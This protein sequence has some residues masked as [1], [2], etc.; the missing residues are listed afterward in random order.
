MKDHDE[1]PVIEARALAD[2]FDLN[3]FTAH[4]HETVKIKLGTLR[5]AA[6]LFRILCDD[7]VEQAEQ[8]RA[9][10]DCV[11]AADRI[12]QRLEGRKTPCQP[13]PATSATESPRS[14]SS[15]RSSDLPPAARRP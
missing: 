1:E 7:A 14:A 9:A 10:H 4:D 3:S 12:I 15:Q 11:T 6:R 5:N 8:A 2:E 13:S